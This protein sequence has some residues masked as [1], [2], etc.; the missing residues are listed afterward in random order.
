MDQ[1]GAKR[2][3]DSDGDGK[4]ELDIGAVETTTFMLDT[5]ADVADEVLHDGNAKTASD[6]VSLR[7]AVQ[8]ANVTLG[9][10]TIYLDDA[11]YQL[12]VDG[13]A[14][15][16][17]AIGDLDVTEDLVI[18]GRGADRSIIDAAGISRIFDVHPDAS[19][20]LINLQ[21][22][23]GSDGFGGLIRA[24]R[25]EI[26]LRNVYL[27]GGLATYGG[28][29]AAESSVVEIIASTIA[30]SEAVMDGGAIHLINS[31]ARIANSTLSGNVAGGRG[32][33][34]RSDVDSVVKI[35]NS[36]VSF[37]H[38]DFGGG[39]SADKAPRMSNT[40]L[41]KNEMTASG[42]E[43]DY[44]GY[45]VSEGNN[46]VGVYTPIST[47]TTESVG[48]NRI[49]GTITIDAVA[50]PP[51]PFEITVDSERMLV[52]S[53]VGNVLHVD[54]GGFPTPIVSHQAGA[55]VVI[56]FSWHADD[57]VG[58]VDPLLYP[59]T[60]GT[61]GVPIHPLQSSSPAIDQANDQLFNGLED[62]SDPENLINEIGISYLYPIRQTSTYIPATDL[63]SLPRWTFEARKGIYDETANAFR[64]YYDFFA[65]P[66]S[67]HHV[68]LS[69][70]QGN[71]AV[72]TTVSHAQPFV[73]LTD[74]RQLPRIHGSAM[75]IGATEYNP[76]LWVL[77][78]DRA[79]I[80]R[81]PGDASN[82]AEF[83][84][85]RSDLSGNLDVGYATEFDNADVNTADFEPGNVFS[86]IV[87]FTGD[88][89]VK[90]VA[91]SPNPDDEFERDDPFQVS[92]STQQTGVTIHRS[93]ANGLIVNDDRIRLEVSHPTMEEG[94][95]SSALQYL[96]FDVQLFGEV[97]EPFELS[98][99][100]N[101][102]T[103]SVD[104]DLGSADGRFH[105]TTAPAKISFLGKDL[106]IQ[107]IRIPVLPDNIVEAHETILLSLL[108]VDGIRDPQIA[109]MIDLPDTPAIGTIKNDDSATISFLPQTASP[110]GDLVDGTRSV[111]VTVSLSNPIDRDLNMTASTVGVTATAT[112]P[113]PDF[114]STTNPLEFAIGIQTRTFALNIV[115]D[116][117]IELDE[118]V[119][120]IL[121]DLDVF[122]LPSL[123][124]ADDITPAI[125]IQNGLFTIE[126][127][128][129]ARLTVN[130]AP[131]PEGQ[132]GPTFAYLEV[133]L[134]APQPFPINFNV[135]TSDDSAI[136]GVDY[137]GVDEVH[138]FPSMTNA[139]VILPVEIVNDQIVELDEYFDVHIDLLGAGGFESEIDVV[140]GF[141]TILG[142]LETIV[143]ISDEQVAEG[144]IHTK[145]M[146]FT[147]TLNRAT[148]SGPFTATVNIVQG[149]A[150]P[151]D[152][153]LDVATVLPFQGNALE[154]V[155][156]SVPI[157]NDAAYEPDET[158]TV[159]VIPSVGGIL[160]RPGTGTILNNDVATADKK[161][162][163]RPLS[164]SLIAEGSSPQVVGNVVQFLVSRNDAAVAADVNFAIDS[165]AEASVTPEDFVP[166]TN[167][168]GTLSFAEGQVSR[169]V[170]FELAPDSVV[171][172]DEALV[173]MLSNPTA[174]HTLDVDRARIDVTNDD[175]FTISV[176]SI[177]LPEGTAPAN[178][179]ETLF[180][181][182]VTAQGEIDDSVSV[183]VS[184]TDLP[185]NGPDHADVATDVSGLTMPDTLTFS[186]A[187][188]QSYQVLVSADSIYE[189]NEIFR[190]MLDGLQADGR[191]QGI[192]LSD[193]Y[194][195]I[196]NDDRFRFEVSDENVLEGSGV[197][198]T[199]TYGTT[200]LYF[201]VELFGAVN[202]PF[203]LELVIEDGTAS[204]SDD[205]MLG[206][207]GSSVTRTLHF[208]GNDREIATLSIPVLGDHLVEE[209]ETFTV[210]L[211]EVTNS[212]LNSVADL[213]PFPA[214]GT[215][216]N[217]DKATISFEPFDVFEG[218]LTAG[219]TPLIQ[220]VN[221]TV[222]LSNPVDRD[223]TITASAEGVPGL[224]G[225]T[226]GEDFF[227]NLEPL[228][229][230]SGETT[231]EFSFDVIGDTEFELDEEVK[232]VL[233]NL[234]VVGL[235]S[236]VMPNT[237]PAVEYSNSNNSLLIQNDDH[238]NLLIDSR[239]LPEGQDAVFTVTLDR[240]LPFP[241]DFRVQTLANG[242]ATP[243]ADFG[244]IDL[245]FTIAAG[246][247]AAIMVTVP[248][249][250]DAHVELD[251]QF[252]VIIADLSAG[253]FESEINTG[254]GTGTI[255]S[256][257]DPY[258]IVEDGEFVEGNPAIL[259]QY[260][261]HVTLTAILN[262]D[263]PG[264]FTA[265]AQLTPGTAVLNED[266]LSV[267]PVID[268]LG[269]AGEK[270]YLVLP[271]LMDTVNEPDETFTV[272]VIPDSMSGVGSQSG[273]ATILND[274]PAPVAPQFRIQ[275]LVPTVFEGTLPEGPA[276]LVEFLVS[277]NDA[278]TAAEVSYQLD[279]SVVDSVAPDDLVD[280]GELTG[281]VSLAVGESSK[282]VTL[283]LSRDSLVE[284][285]E[286]VS[287]TLLNPTAGHTLSAVSTAQV[288]VFDDDTFTI[289][290]EP[291]TMDEGTDPP[292]PPTTNFIF[293]ISTV[294]V[295]DVP[296]E[297]T[298]GVAPIFG[299]GDDLAS[300]GSDI[301][302]ARLPRTNLS[303][304]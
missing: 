194:G 247:N 233:S 158:F 132:G 212:L 115:G 208:M 209:A 43:Q 219:Q 44:E 64:G 109:S 106:E 117:A 111:I 40:I 173:L 125:T 229:F 297:V 245:P 252:T 138:W 127:D 87:T 18:V 148:V 35:R 41:A 211:Q 62:F 279:M 72:S 120:L 86:G 277:R 241:I 218:N 8:E 264:G 5:S 57:Q 172:R 107:Q 135:R 97:G 205:L 34:I 270:R 22:R 90:R 82:T 103:G 146:V 272:T 230:F 77:E 265:S 155:Q 24:M 186:G 217:N 30:N 47:T 121:S 85:Y 73:A 17:D 48:T 128:D 262:H 174:T 88:E 51:E 91:F 33:A 79:T 304:V 289:R 122:D 63:R 171:E 80:E 225:A 142:D 3:S 119:N 11:I 65:T 38:A 36:T 81:N 243:G 6:T 110:E 207:F 160:T 145:D 74:Q 242:T 134:D 147:A 10:A 274:D 282:V 150:L 299:P 67:P 151:G 28:A 105:P 154:T 220:P 188:T 92:I 185:G 89:T 285:D 235:T 258:V 190:V 21:L 70:G 283:E 254:F 176:N 246:T 256:D 257:T 168:S 293:N 9:R 215:I 200:W 69:P 226:A 221:V 13:T 37:N 55:P 224:H 116:D 166:G 182:T 175:T 178:P 202:Q 222:L 163:I 99:V 112:G 141:G 210:T 236:L 23:G 139:S 189:Q 251:E 95:S 280:V 284:G 201:D 287:V 140:G 165:G 58:S 227:D 260:Q 213:S 192:V 184:P 15:A 253:G 101:D 143:F 123:V 244:A 39:V 130:A 98:Y 275:P 136:D 250:N 25:G 102:G 133:S 223:V 126:N 268:F 196:E 68:D 54:R 216:F 206:A 162:S 75:D 295:I 96:V 288:Y 276:S 19:L 61:N 131:V 261:N 187:G 71:P 76:G 84:I 1:R 66:T 2:L 124:L 269:Y 94:T 31:N 237:N 118:T 156:F 286:V 303:L 177:Q 167:L 169:I 180:E 198:G 248:L 129:R 238:V 232:L 231:K 29:I 240:Q 16:S 301:P 290:V 20:T 278:T 292:G 204:V 164:T 26:E 50:L 263:V 291:L 108:N 152:D 267:G 100:V 191:E 281:T 228:T 266:Y 197:N 49:Y 83:I 56:S 7:A 249:L 114:I 203:D 45:V 144:N 93:S 170:S 60:D 46:L 104:T 12:T 193:G 273:T 27:D 294:G 199:T 296:V 179:N 159:S 32:G 42:Q 234:D 298:A 302:S 214:T 239:Q 149:S 161:F 78:T 137:F 195:T 14:E 4:L 181:F 52:T 183:R 271:L 59:L 157:V 53:V 153:Y 259:G 255:L 113:N 300:I